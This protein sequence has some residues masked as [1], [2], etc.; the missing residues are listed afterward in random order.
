[1]TD[2]IVPDS[3]AVPSSDWETPFDR[4]L[5][6]PPLKLLGRLL[7]LNQLDRMYREMYAAGGDGPFMGRVLEELGIETVVSE[8]DLAR[9]PEEGRLII[10][11][12]HPFG[13]IDG[14]ILLTLLK[15]IRPDIKALV[16]F[17]LGRIPE[18]AENFILADP[19]ES[20]EAVL[21]NI[22]PLR[23]TIG[24]LKRGEVILFFPAGEVS[25]I[26][27]KNWRVCDGQWNP[28]VA[29]LARKTKSPILP[30]YFE[31]SNSAFFQAAGLIHPLLRTALLPSEML[32]KRNS[33]VRLRIGRVI[34][35]ER[36]FRFSR[37]EDMMRYLRWRTYMLARSEDEEVRGLSSG[38]S[39]LIPVAE[40][41]T[42]RASV[43]PV[44]ADV[45]ALGPDRVLVEADPFAVY[46]AEAAE[47][48]NLLQEIGRL[49]ETT[50]REVGEGT[51]KAVDL[52]EYDEY[53]LHLF[54]WNRKKS[55]VVGAYRLGLTDRIRAEHGLKGLYTR[56]LFSY[57]GRF[58]NKID[59]AVELGRSFVRSEYQRTFRAL[60]L[61]WKGIGAFVVQN[62]RYKYLFGPVSITSEYDAVSRHL[63]AHFF[64]K[65]NH[66]RSLARL[67]KARN[68]L[69]RSRLKGRELKAVLKLLGDVQGLSDVVADIEEDE[70]GIPILLKQYVKLGG[71][72]LGFNVDQDFSDVLDAF[73]LVDLTRT[74]Q[75]ILVKYMGESGAQSFLQ[76][77]RQNSVS[78]GRAA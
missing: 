18:I 63:I 25:H 10:V 72:T 42:A 52:D 9:V 17:L 64:R 56:T 51:G 16:N 59:P 40:Q 29:R 68:P 37:D 15:Q 70:K 8:R 55:E 44:A 22:K 35:A 75:R 39:G 24:R 71:K 53:Y 21:S 60:M 32:K 31:G 4:L 3:H 61:L 43:D 47:I 20:K 78:A 30:V 69:R 62:P 5:P 19:F 46:L 1:M 54:V 66:H 65:N 11:A 23:E 73:I 41:I 50:F 7:K 28:I 13:G 38:R 76:A 77:H 49:R 6:S 57:R 14:M 36:L 45:E 67:V 48:P 2:R 12:N 27:W 58:L 26:T 33:R 34:P 74:D